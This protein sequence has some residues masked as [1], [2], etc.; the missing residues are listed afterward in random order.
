M[1][2]SHCR[3][4]SNEN[5]LSALQQKVKLLSLSTLTDDH[6][7]HI[8]PDSEIA[9][10]NKNTNQVTKTLAISDV[11]TEKDLNQV[12]DLIIHGEGR[13]FIDPANIVHRIFSHL[14]IKNEKAR[15]DS[16]VDIYISFSHE[17]Q[18]YESDKSLFVVGDEKQ[19]IYSFQGADHSFYFNSSWS[20]IF[21]KL[22]YSFNSY[23]F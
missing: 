17:G 16:K 7:I 23:S 14:G 21:Y 1:L 19:S 8:L 4:S 6:S 11:F 18:S 2:F 10:I 9:I 22:N 15:G 5:Y 20:S 13:S 3:R 12:H